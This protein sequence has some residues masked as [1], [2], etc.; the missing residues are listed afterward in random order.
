MM[1]LNNKYITPNVTNEIKTAL[2]C[3]AAYH[4]QCTC[5]QIHV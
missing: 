3:V 1:G 4:I 2:S 5:T